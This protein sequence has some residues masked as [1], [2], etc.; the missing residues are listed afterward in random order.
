MLPA[1]DCDGHARR[2]GHPVL[3]DG[4]TLRSAAVAGV[5]ARL[6]TLGSAED[7]T[8]RRRVRAREHELGASVCGAERAALYARA[9]IA[10]AA[11]VA[12][13]LYVLALGRRVRRVVEF[14]AS[15]GCS[16]IHLAAAIRDAGG[17]SVVTTEL[18]AEKARGAEANLVEAGLADLVD[19]RVGDALETLRDLAGPVDLLFLDGANDLYLAVLALVEPRLGPGGLVVA[20]MSR[21]DPHHARYRRHVG[22]PARGYASIE[23]PLDDGVVLSARRP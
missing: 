4:S 17:G 20:D 21:D 11:D 13:L 22:D 9:P 8:A 3:A 16:T 14:G 1:V 15:L 6:R 18:L 19:V 23:V 12:E 10:V 2:L 7:E 5:L